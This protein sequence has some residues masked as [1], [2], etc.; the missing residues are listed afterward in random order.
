MINIKPSTTSTIVDLVTLKT[1]AGNNGVLIMD[2]ITC[3]VI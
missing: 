2:Q 1:I 3:F